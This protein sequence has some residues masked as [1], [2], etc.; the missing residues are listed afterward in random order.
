MLDWSQIKRYDWVLFYKELSEELDSLRELDDRDEILEK[1]CRFIFGD[2][3]AINNERVNPNGVYDP[4]S[5][6]Y[7]LA[8]RTT[9]NQ[10]ED[11]YSRA[12]NSFGL[13][14]DLPTDQIFPIPGGQSNALYHW[15][16]RYADENGAEVAIDNIWWL[17]RQAVKG[18]V[19]KKYFSSTLSLKGV[20]LAKLTQTLFLINGDHFFPADKGTLKFFPEHDKLEKEVS[21]RGYLAYHDFMGSVRRD[22][23]GCKFSEIN[24]LLYLIGSDRLK[25]SSNS[26]QISTGLEG[27]HG[28]S[29]LETFQEKDSVY[30]GGSGEHKSRGGLYPVDQVKPGDIMFIREGTKN[31][32]GIGVVLENDFEESGYYENGEIRIIWINREPRKSKKAIGD[33]TGFNQ[34]TGKTYE[35][36]AETYSDAINLI[37]RIG[38][39]LQSAS[40]NMNEKNSDNIMMPL[41]QIL[42]G[43]PGTGKTYHTMD[44]AVQIAAPGEYKPKDHDA[45]K[46]VF[47][48]L[49][50]SGKVVFTTFH[51]SLSYEDFIEGIKPVMEEDEGDL[52]YEIRPGIF[53]KICVEAAFAILNESKK[54]ETESILDFSIAFEKFT[55]LLEERMAVENEVSITTKN[56]GKLIVDSIS[57]Q[58]NIV[59]RHT[60]SSKT[61]T[62]SKNRVSKLHKA[63][64][65]LNEVHNIDS[66]FRE[67][68]GGNNSTANWAVLNSIR[69]EIPILEE[70][71][72]RLDLSWDEKYEIVREMNSEDFVEK[73][74]TPYVLIIDEINR[75]NVSQIFGELITLIEKD[76]RLGQE[77][78]IF[79][80]L[81]YSQSV[82]GTPSN[83]Y[84][85]GTMNTADRSVEALDTALRR[86]FSFIEMEPKPE[87]LASDKLLWFLWRKDWDYK[88]EDDE[89]INHESSLL[90][91]LGGN[92]VDKKKYRS[93]ENSKKADGLR[94]NVF[95][96]IVSFNGLNF[97]K[98]LSTINERIELLID[99]DHKIGHSY[100]FS[101]IGANDC[102]I[103]LYSIFYDKIIPLLE[104]YFYG[105]F[106]KI[107]LVLGS[108]FVEDIKGTDVKFADFKMEDI[109]VLK[110][111]RLYKIIDYRNPSHQ[112]AFSF[113]E[114]VKNIYELPVEE[115]KQTESE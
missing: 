10:F 40:S 37:N 97:E 7:A 81:P 36:F 73:I 15:E 18:T 2:E 33:W 67:V 78:E 13:N 38:G 88:W 49:I 115:N 93:L 75:G 76:K 20:G 30:P 100:F 108:G 98:L 43:P 12:K 70:V 80:K 21:N 114:A 101:L 112:S 58:R 87:L 104:E 79:V 24:L 83:L 44:K 66:Q 59:V 16:S 96:G 113:I 31:F 77:D 91:I 55:E 65:D 86:R 56:G 51:Q 63:Y 46:K 27:K 72:K 42:Y 4:F 90:K 85:I 28:K 95:Q 48:R 25:L 69:E 8:Q 53:M 71:E 64:P 9:K 23:P 89:W 62:I 52:K 6:I 19:G 54:H 102:E 61:Y 17:F 14:T 11:F 32:G 26:F 68:I 50:Q 1:H 82:F 107:G 39:K 29:Y 60:G 74:G 94:K 5:V 47:D 92:V 57:K 110:E 106:G 105:D 45:N 84:L 99:K 109:S 34:A 103:E 3:H 111:K 22:F 35:L 41:N